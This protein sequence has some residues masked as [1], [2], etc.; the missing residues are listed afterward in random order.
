[1][2]IKK[3]NWILVGGTGRNIGKTTAAE[4]II[5]KL[6]KKCKIV[7]VKVS[8]VMPNE[9][10][11]HGNH[12][13][14]DRITFS[15]IEEK[16]YTGSKDS[17][18]F[19]RAGAVKSYFVV[20]KDGN[21]EDVLF[22]LEKQLDSDNYVVCES[23]GFRSIIKPFLFVMIKGKISN[24]PKKNLEFLLASADVVLP[25]LDSDALIDFV[26]KIQV[27]K[28]RIMISEI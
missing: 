3:S 5:S 18:R 28:D 19:L 6:S 14:T 1:M 13:I 11:F 2:E 10:A 20:A 7:G 8:K 25:A 26:E 9:L 22:E 17:M 12:E 27:Q 16:N 21:L 24:N 23:N 4:H 15:L